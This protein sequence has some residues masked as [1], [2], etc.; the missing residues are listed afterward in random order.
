MTRHSSAVLAITVA[1]SLGFCAPWAGAQCVNLVHLE[2]WHLAG[3]PSACTPQPCLQC[4]LA[5]SVAIVAVEWCSRKVN[6]FGHLLSTSINAGLIDI[7]NLAGDIP[8]PYLEIF[9]GQGDFPYSVQPTQAVIG[10]VDRIRVVDP[11]TRPKT[12]LAGHVAGNLGSSLGGVTVGKVYRLDVDGALRGVF[13][14]QSPGVDFPLIHAG[15]TVAGTTI[16]CNL[17]TINRVQVANDAL[18]NISAPGGEITNVLASNLRGNVI[19]RDFIANIDVTG[20][21]GTTVPGPISIDTTGASAPI[22]IVKGASINATIDAGTLAARGNIGQIRTTSGTFAGSINAL[23]AQDPSPG[24]AVISIAGSVLASSSITLAAGGLKGQMIVNQGNA[25]GTWGAGASVTVGGVALSPMPYYNNTSAS[26]G[27]GAVGLAPFNINGEDCVPRNGHTLTFAET[28]TVLLRHYGPLLAWTGQPVE[29]AW[30]ESG[31]IPWIILPEN[32]FIVAAGPTPRDLVITA[33]TNFDFK[34]GF[35]YRI[36]PK[37][38]VL[39]CAAVTGNP[40]VFPYE[41]ILHGQ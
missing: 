41:Y 36:R 6:I 31:T 22:G 17:G 23:N 1:G 32:E 9:I 27:G 30:R 39:R 21:I 35:D 8:D 2:E 29:I 28:T 25:G 15:S 20:A 7:N 24:V 37:P 16:T 40:D 19:A 5:P 26:I 38:G 10:S 3:C 33:V 18:G 34:V 4:N 13:M 11:N 14:D 12:R